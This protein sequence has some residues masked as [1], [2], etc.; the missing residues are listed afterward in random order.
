MAAFLDRAKNQTELRPPT[1]TFADVPT[2]YWAYGWIERFYTLAITT[3]CGTDDAG[4]RIFC[5]DRG[6][7]RAEMAVFLIRA[8]P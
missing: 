3:G 2:G 1:P 7:T 5:P 6:V 8:Y 4:N